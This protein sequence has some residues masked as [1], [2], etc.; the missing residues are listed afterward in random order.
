V[1]KSQRQIDSKVQ[2]DCFRRDKY[3]CVYCNRDDV[4]LT[5]DHIMT[6]EN[7]GPTTVENLVT[8]CKK[9]NKTRGNTPYGDWLESDYYKQVSKNVPQ[10]EKNWLLELNENL[11]TGKIKPLFNKRKR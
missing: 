8:A 6:W 7:G 5:I 11:K 2:W 1:R 9:C 3:K 10:V 4:P